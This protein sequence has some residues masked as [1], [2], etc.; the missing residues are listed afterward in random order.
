[1]AAMGKRLTTGL[2]GLAGLTGVVALMKQSVDA[3]KVSFDESR[4]QQLDSEPKSITR[5]WSGTE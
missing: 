3:S 5:N 4:T 2:L 1:M